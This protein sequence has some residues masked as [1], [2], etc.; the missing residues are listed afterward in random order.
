MRTT[1]LVA[2]VVLSAPW[3]SSSLSAQTLLQHFSQT[4]INQVASR[5]SNTLRSGGMIGVVADIRACYAATSM[6]KTKANGTAIA[7]CMLYDYAAHDLDAGM[8]TNLVAQGLNDPGTVSS[9]LS[10]QAIGA[11]FEI[12]APIPFGN[13]PA[14]VGV[15]FDHAPSE[16]LNELKF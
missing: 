13:D 9:Y 2:F 4:T 5:F 15:Y 7:F 8:R 1:A 12:Y 14:S 6:T 10:D 3:V 16:V 11:R